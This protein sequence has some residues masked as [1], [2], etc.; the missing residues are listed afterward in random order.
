MYPDILEP[1]ALELTEKLDFLK[2][3]NLQ[4]GK[5]HRSRWRAGGIY[6]DQKYSS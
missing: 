4:L 6:T 1:A 5:K 2:R 3:F